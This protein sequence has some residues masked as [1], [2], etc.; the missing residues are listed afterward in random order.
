MW[1]YWSSSP[2]SSASSPASSSSSGWCSWGL[3][4]GCAWS[5]YPVW[6]IFWFTIF[7]DFENNSISRGYILFNVEHFRLCIW[8]IYEKFRE[9]LLVGEKCCDA[10][11]I[12]I[13]PEIF[14]CFEGPFLNFTGFTLCSLDIMDYPIVL[15]DFRQLGVH[16]VLEFFSVSTKFTRSYRRTGLQARAPIVKRSYLCLS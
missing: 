12:W 7:K 11:D 10:H 9:N 2:S 3:D 8:L 4:W 13:T 14:C 6:S 5:L 16:C 1:S 15:M